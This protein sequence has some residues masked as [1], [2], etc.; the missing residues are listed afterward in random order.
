M[1]IKRQW[2]HIQGKKK[3]KFSHISTSHSVLK[4]KP[5]NQVWVIRVIFT[6][7]FFISKKQRCAEKLY[8]N[9]LSLLMISMELQLKYISHGPL[10]YSRNA[11][12]KAYNPIQSINQLGKTI[13]NCIL[14]FR[15]IVVPLVADPM[16]VDTV[17]CTCP[18]NMFWTKSVTNDCRMEVLY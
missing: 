17:Q 5:F 14:D 2:L 9:T 12:N 16:L 13:F 18:K 8:T 4:Y 7:T 10:L 6:R 3:N 1:N 15:F 11:D